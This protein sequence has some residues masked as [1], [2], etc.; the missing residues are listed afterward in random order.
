MKR[1][2]IFIVIQTLTSAIYWSSVLLLRTVN[3]FL[4]SFIDTYTILVYF[5]LV[6]GFV[7]YYIV[8]IFPHVHRII[9]LLTLVFLGVITILCGQLVFEVFDRNSLFNEFE[10]ISRCDKTIVYSQYRG[11]FNGGRRIYTKPEGKIS[12][13]ITESDSSIQIYDTSFPG[14]YIKCLEQE[15]YRVEVLDLSKI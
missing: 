11:V 2:I 14:E 8:K 3:T 9:G 10:I 1:T 15:G 12:S 6:I 7:V 4:Y 5:I 13:Y